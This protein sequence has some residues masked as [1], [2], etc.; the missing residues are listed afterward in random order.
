MHGYA[1]LAVI[2]RGVGLLAC[3]MQDE[4]FVNVCRLNNRADRKEQQTRKRTHAQ[5]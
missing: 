4:I 2:L 3:F 5:P 1:E